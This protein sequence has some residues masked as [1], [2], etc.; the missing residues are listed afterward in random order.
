V[1][2]PAVWAKQRDEAE[3]AN[4][5]ED[6]K[7]NA[8]GRDARRASLF[9]RRLFDPARNCPLDRAELATEAQRHRGRERD[10]GALSGI[11]S[12]AYD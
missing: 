3:D 6:G 5:A 7:E 1:R 2:V 4:D 8:A 10:R 9:A 12:L 11:T